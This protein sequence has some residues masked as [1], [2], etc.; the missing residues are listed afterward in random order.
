[1][2]NERSILFGFVLF[3]FFNDLYSSLIFHNTIKS[4]KFPVHKIS[5]FIFFVKTLY[6]ISKN[7]LWSYSL[8]SSQIQQGT[9]RSLDV[10]SFKFICQA[11]GSRS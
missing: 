5:F 3:Q 2:F 6:N 9:M 4:M 7:A 11:A 10:N 8:A 1:M